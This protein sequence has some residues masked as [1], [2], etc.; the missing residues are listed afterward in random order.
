MDLEDDILNL[1]TILNSRY[2]KHIKDKVSALDL[3]LNLISDCMK[4]WLAMQQ[5]WMYLEGIFIGSED[6]RDQLQDA[7]NEF[8][9]IHHEFTGIMAGLQQNSNAL[10]NCTTDSRIE[11]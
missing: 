4:V 9:R 7:A 2:V 10:K 3:D 8:D 11:T 1:Q 6:I 5:K